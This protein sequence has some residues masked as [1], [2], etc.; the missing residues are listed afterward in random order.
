MY[1]GPPGEDDWRVLVARQG[2]YI[3]TAA[4][5]IDTH[6][7][8]DHHAEAKVEVE[9]EKEAEAEGSKSKGKKRKR[10]SE[11]EVSERYNEDDADVTIISSDR[12]AF[13]V[14][15]LFLVRAS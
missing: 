1:T 11:P 8:E 13:K 9:A 4:G 12:T 7:P 2:R 6:E 15:S 5:W 3:E 14:H 10:D